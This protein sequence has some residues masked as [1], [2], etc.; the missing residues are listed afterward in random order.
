MYSDYYQKKLRDRNK[1]ETFA[2]LTDR[3]WRVLINSTKLLMHLG[4]NITVIIIPRA[5]LRGRCVNVY[6]HTRR[7]RVEKTHE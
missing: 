4:E 1:A 6:L 3:V 7:K 2:E 5:R